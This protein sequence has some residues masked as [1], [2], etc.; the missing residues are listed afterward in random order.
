MRIRT[1]SFKNKYLKYEYDK[2]VSQN[3]TI[4][5]PKNQLES[6]KFKLQIYDWC[7]VIAKAYIGI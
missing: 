7:S 1:S 5:Y 2:I 4:L 6:F 3:R